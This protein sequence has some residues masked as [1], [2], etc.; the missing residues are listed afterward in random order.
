MGLDNDLE[1]TKNDIHSQM[2]LVFSVF[3][4]KLRTKD[5]IQ[6][7]CSDLNMSSARELRRSLHDGCRIYSC[8]SLLLHH[9]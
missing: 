2:S 5:Q 4:Q 3:R 1:M 8:T 7:F 6:V 9:H